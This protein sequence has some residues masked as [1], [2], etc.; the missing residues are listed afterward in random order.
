MHNVIRFSLDISAGRIFLFRLM[1]FVFM[2]HIENIKN[3]FTFHLFYAHAYIMLCGSQFQIDEHTFT[4][5]LRIGNEMKF[6]TKKISQQIDLHLKRLQ[7]CVFVAL[8]LRSTNYN[9]KM[10]CKCKTH[11]YNCKCKPETKSMSVQMRRENKKRAYLSLQQDANSNR[12]CTVFAHPH[13]MYLCLVSF[14]TTKSHMIYTQKIVNIT[15]V[16]CGN[17][18]RGT[19]EKKGIFAARF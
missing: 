1:N 11:T 19:K 17:G 3:K 10:A 2:F 13:T 7:L 12:S 15:S 6:G 4:I 16:H 5:Y 18:A 9:A 14:E 8:Q